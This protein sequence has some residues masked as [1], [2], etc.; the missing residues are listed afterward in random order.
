MREEDRITEA[1]I[2]AAIEV[3]RQLG[4]G[5]FESTYEAGLVYEL[6]LG[7]WKVERQIARPVIYKGVE[8]EEAYRIDLLVEDKV[9]VEIKAVSALLP[10]HEA[11]ILTYLKLSRRRIGLLINFTVPLLKN[12]IKRFVNG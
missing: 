1:I 10:V 8:I 7:S 3:H 6:K 12:G 5:L 9:I 4:P 11:Q 2:G